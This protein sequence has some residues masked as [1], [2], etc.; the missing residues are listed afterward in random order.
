M[1]SSKTASRTG[2]AGAVHPRN[3]KVVID[4]PDRKLQIRVLVLL[5]GTVLAKASE[6]AGPKR[7]KHE[8]NAVEECYLVGLPDCRT[9]VGDALIG[10]AE[11]AISDHPEEMG[12][13]APRSLS[14]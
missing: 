1:P 6:K 13:I 8:G 9:V 10:R 11:S 7:V 5:I 2:R 3:R 4:H 14:G 12:V